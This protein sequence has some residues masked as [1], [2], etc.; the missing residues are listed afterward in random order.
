[1]FGRVAAGT[2]SLA[3][4]GTGGFTIT[5]ALGGGIFGRAFAS[6]GDVNG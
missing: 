1:V 5:G 6:A 3:T 4:L 2:V